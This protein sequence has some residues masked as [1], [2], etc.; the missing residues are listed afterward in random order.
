MD[1]REI[2][3]HFDTSRDPSR[4]LSREREIFGMVEDGRLPEI[5]RFWVNTECLVRGKVRSAKYGWYNEELARKM[6][7][8]VIERDTGGGVVYHD[9]GNLNWSFFL[10]SPGAF[11]S[12]AAAFEGASKHVIK[13]LGALG[14]RAHFSPPNRIDVLGRKV[15]GMAARSTVKALLVH[16]TLLLESNLDKLN[17]LCIPPPGSPAVANINDLVKGVDPD[18]IMKAFVGVLRDGGFHVRVTDAL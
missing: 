17:M 13:A 16:G 2:L 1:E 15:S 11:P 12:P 10:R 7:V 4:N 14:V 6:G 8:R 18:M 5:V 9:E 3:V